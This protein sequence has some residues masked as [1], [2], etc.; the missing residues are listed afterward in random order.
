L[1]ETTLP[2]TRR[3]WRSLDRL[4]DS[5]AFQEAATPELPD[6]AD[7][8]PDAVSRRTMLTIMGASFA[9][10]GLQGCRR[11]VEHIVPYVAAP[12]TV[13]PGVPKHYATTMP[14]STDAYGVVVESHEGRPTKIEGNELHPSSRGAASAWG[15]AS[16]LGLYDPDR[17]AQVQRRAAEGGH[18]L[19]AW[20]D[21]ETFW[22]ERAGALGDGSGLA[23]LSAA[24]SSPTLARLR[25]AFAARFP[26]ARW[27]VYEPAGDAN[28]FAGVELA[29]GGAHRPVYHL[30]RARV[31][32]ALD[33]DFLHTE[34]ESVRNARGFS[35]GRRVE[36]TDDAMSRLYA[37]ESTYTLTGAA[38]DHRLRMKSGAVAGFA[39]ALAR[40]LGVAAPASDAPAG[41]EGR[42][43][44]IAADLRAAG[45]AALVIAGRRQPP[46]VHAL[47]L[48]INQA[49][50][51]LGTTVTLHELDGAG[52]G[53]PDA[54]R[55]LTAAVESEAV[56]TL[57]VLGGNPAYDAPGDVG[58]A[59]ALGKVAHAVHLSTHFDETSRL[60]EWH[61]PATHYLEAW[62]DARAAD[63]TLSVVQPLIAPLLGGRSDV[64]VVNLLATGVHAP[65][66][67]LVR[68]TWNDVFG[69]DEKAWRRVLHDGLLAESAAAVTTA[70]GDVSG[71][72]LP[73]AGEG[74]EVTFH[75][76]AKVHDGRYANVGWLQELPDPI[77]KITWDNA[78]LVSPATAERLG[79][80]IADPRERPHHARKVALTAGGRTLELPVFVLPGQ[81]DDSIAVHLGYG[82]TAAGRVGDGVGVDVNVL[83]STSS[84]WIAAATAGLA[85]G[86]HQLV[87]TQEHWT[88][89][90]R[91]LIVEGTLDEYG[92]NPH[93]VAHA[94]HQLP[95]SQLFP[96]HEYG[97]GHQWGMT[98]DLGACIG[99]NACVVACQSE[100]NVPIVGKEQIS[101]GREMHWLRIDRY[102]VSHGDDDGHG[103]AAE[104]EMAFQPIP[105]MH[106][107][108]AP[109]EQ[110]CPVAA[111]VHDAEG[112]NAMVY[113]RCIG[114][115]YC[116]N[117]CPYKVRRFNFFNYTKDTPEILKIAANP[118]VTVRSR[119]VMEK[120]TYCLQ[121][122]SEA[123]IA[124]GR[125][126][127]PVRDGEIRTACQQTCPTQ[128]IV[129]GD[130]ND[131][132]SR[133]SR[134]KA[135][136]LDYTL[137]GEL[138]NRPRTSFLA[139]LR[140]PN[141]E[142]EEQA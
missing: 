102:F 69:T 131:P 19:A 140:N 116:S 8:P 129:F 124:A 111:T 80:A 126:G 127:R 34:S 96:Y 125:E 1:K 114:T 51:A 92:K 26:A 87:Q 93:F 70:V 42:L 55:A 78:A 9:F 39:A 135:R 10:A 104:P 122:I 119:G 59:D 75:V 128:A 98:I 113:N 48:A 138:N 56:D 37:V 67:D 115:R 36:S 20:T 21:F 40:E 81:A 108:N 112:L 142:W 15:Q 45:D 22:Q 136:E 4:L 130:V 85:A 32:L 46:A 2:T 95:D 53:G 62:G 14:L 72:A 68:A 25:A 137:L 13:I 77:T 33:S 57:V 106:C 30:D 27:V 60:A 97:E 12:E 23:V 139:R 3:Y 61:L 41:F 18:A 105:C 5:P 82:R 49:L 43:R 17:S 73:E 16:I 91:H 133:V 31:V 101:R 6:G 100:N 64:E 110:V 35:Q 52:Y 107:E 99:C 109:C 66:H 79:L 86:R 29:T 11:P 83:R 88:M 65:G 103:V 84:P 58:F 74:L 54:L 24:Y 89:A 7:L 76:D 71:V 44:T 123:K 38:A 47:A 94:L 118:D 134:L 117:N 63:G 50:G 90:G 121:R 120:C 28:V 141:P 132:E